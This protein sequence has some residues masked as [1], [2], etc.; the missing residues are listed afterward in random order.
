MAKDIFHDFC[1]KIQINLDNCFLFIIKDKQMS[2]H[3][4]IQAVTDAD[5]KIKVEK[6]LSSLAITPDEAINL[7]YTQILLHNGLPFEVK[8]PNQITVSAMN[9]SEEKK[10]EFFNCVEDLLHDLND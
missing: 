9:D 7:F 8:K 4:L 3:V 5:L 10:G 6:I 2:N 1:G